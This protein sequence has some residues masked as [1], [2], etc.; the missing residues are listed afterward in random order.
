[1][2]TRE[3][4]LVAAAEHLNNLIG[5]TGTLEPNRSVLVSVGWP[6]RDQNGRV[7]GQCTSNGDHERK[8]HIFV[9]PTQTEPTEVLCILLHEL[10]HAADWCQHGHK[11]PFRRTWKAVGFTG[12]PTE[13]TPGEQLRQQ[14]EAIAIDA[15]GHYPHEEIAGRG[16][17]EPPPQKAR[18]LKLQCPGCG[19]IIR[20]TRLWIE[21]GLPT[22]ACGCLFDPEG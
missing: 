9:A 18:M 20:A 5:E 15:L 1:M 11:G 2:K 6:R 7:V 22:C 17:D 14:L 12:K 13:C 19:Y 10:I 3:A 16:G 8:P 21:T 4:W